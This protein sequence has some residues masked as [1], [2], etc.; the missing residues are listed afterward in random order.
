MRK[1]LYFLWGS[2]TVVLTTY[3]FVSAPVP[4]AEKNAFSAEKSDIEI[5]VVF[6]IVNLINAKTR[7]L[8]T[9]EIV[10]AGK[11]EGLKFDEHW[12]DEGVEAGPLPALFLREVSSNLKKRKSSLALFLGSD[13][14]IAKSNE[15]KGD[16]L[17]RIIAM[18]EGP[19]PQ[20][21]TMEKLGQEIGMYPDF[22]SANGCVTCHNEHP[23]SPKV[24]WKLNDIMGA[25][26]WTYP[27][28]TVSISEM[29]AVIADVYHS[30]EIS[31]AAYL[32][33]TVQFSRPV[34]IGKSW[35]SSGTYSLPSTE[36]FMAVVHNLTGP[37]VIK[38]SYGNPK[39]RLSLPQP[40]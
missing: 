26:T 29:R 31:Y 21:F 24:D 8:Y 11:K 9:K 13:K 37:D 23:N 16:M 39:D 2:L 12:K 35:P 28:S 38:V 40:Q 18:R 5:S 19:G 20:Y 22:A 30:I 14:P 34:A 1:D 6:D 27:K 17:A 4:L 33:D 25:T 15:F 7:Q 32:A 3:L 10:I 36:V